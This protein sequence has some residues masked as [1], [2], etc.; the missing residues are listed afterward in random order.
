MKSQKAAQVFQTRR[1]ATHFTRKKKAKHIACRI[2][3]MRILNTQRPRLTNGSREKV[4]AI[5]LAKVTKLGNDTLNFITASSLWNVAIK[6][7]ILLK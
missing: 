4:L 5:N 6:L 7:G 1:D 3:Q 2:F